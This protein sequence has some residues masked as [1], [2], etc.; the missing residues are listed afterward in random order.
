MPLLVQYFIRDYIDNNLPLLLFFKKPVICSCVHYVIMTIL[1]SQ[2]LCVV[3]ENE[4]QRFW[5]LVLSLWRRYLHSTLVI[6]K[7]EILRFVRFALGESRA[8]YTLRIIP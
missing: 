3:S 7:L 8:A 4:Y 2:H 5:Y 6:I 1:W